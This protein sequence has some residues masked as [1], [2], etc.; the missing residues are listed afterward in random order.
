MPQCRPAP[1]CY[2]AFDPFFYLDAAVLVD[3]TAGT[4]LGA[5][6]S[7]HPS[8]LVNSLTGR[9]THDGLPVGALGRAQ[10]RLSLVFWQD[11]EHDLLDSVMAE[12]E[13][14]A[15]PTGSSVDVRILPSPTA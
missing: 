7:H 5:L 10:H 14:I 8:R 12:A 13:R 15:H 4:T 2:P 9:I 6:R 11:P 3:P 1:V